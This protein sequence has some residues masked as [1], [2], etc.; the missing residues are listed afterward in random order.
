MLGSRFHRFLHLHRF[1]L[2]SDFH[3]DALKEREEKPDYDNRV[4][5]NDLRCEHG[6]NI[7]GSSCFIKFLFDLKKI[8]HEIIGWH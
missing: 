7:Q 3:F 8:E 1:V 6:L 4:G 2:I 5:E